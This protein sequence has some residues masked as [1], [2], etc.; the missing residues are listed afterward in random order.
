M[1][2]KTVQEIKQICR[3]NDFKGYSKYTKKQELLKFLDENLQKKDSQAD[4]ELAKLLY[5]SEQEYFKKKQQEEI[6]A[7]KN[8]HLRKLKE[9]E[10]KK[11]KA[12]NVMKLNQDLEYEKAL[13][14]DIKRQEEEKKKKE[15]EDYK[16]MIDKKY[17]QKIEGDEL[18][19]MRLAR[20]ARF[21]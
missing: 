16:S 17:A 5:E 12:Q 11:I 13:Q 9:V 14:E 6:I 19:Q 2:N 8:E 15:M 7:Q 3:D 1:D 21:S 18:K 10:Q 4:E 20:L